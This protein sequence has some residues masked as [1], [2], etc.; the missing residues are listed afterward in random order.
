[1]SVPSSDSGRAR[2]AQQAQTA[3]N[4]DLVCRAG[5]CASSIPGGGSAFKACYKIEYFLPRSGQLTFVSDFAEFGRD[6]SVMIAARWRSALLR[7]LHTSSRSYSPQSHANAGHTKRVPRRIGEQPTL[8][9]RNRQKCVK[10]CG[11]RRSAWFA[12]FATLHDPKR[13]ISDVA[14]SVEGH[15]M[16]D[17]R[18]STDRPYREIAEKV[19]QLAR[20]TPIAEIQEELFDLADRLERMGETGP[21]IGSKRQG[22]DG[23]GEI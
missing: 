6:F 13:G 18:R 21:T 23:S 2:N 8:L 16:S 11:V 5:R 9:P 22:T 3:A 7:F 15:A 10:S 20:Q 17:Q 14:G 12:R 4:P 19:R 1:V